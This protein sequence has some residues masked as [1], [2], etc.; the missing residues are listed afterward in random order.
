MFLE[1]GLSISQ[2]YL[3]AVNQTLKFKNLEKINEV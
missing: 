2:G 3:K 1:L